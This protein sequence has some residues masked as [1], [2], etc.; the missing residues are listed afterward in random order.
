MKVNVYVDGFNL[1][2]RAI[3]NTRF[4]W[5]NLAAMARAMLRSH[6]V[7]Q[8]RYFTAPIT[9]RPND[10]LAPQ[11]QQLY[12][13]ALATIPNLSIHYGSF[14]TSR[15][16]LPV[17]NPLPGGPSFVEVLRTE[18]KGSDVNLATWLLTDA[19][20]DDFEMAVVVTNDSDLALPI[21]VVRDKFQK[22]IAVFSP[23]KKTTYRLRQA[24]TFHI[25]IHRKY[26]R[27]NQ[28]PPV[29]HDRSGNAIRKPT[30]W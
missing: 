9:P 27:D 19:L 3:K 8:I 1:Y 24:A 7:N 13:R 26:L 16:S 28:F 10:L 15:T 2:Y 18:E 29:L 30:S 4:K 14:L 12:L 11:R 25:A 17:A 23:T 5:L 22:K 6:T 20:D 21:Q